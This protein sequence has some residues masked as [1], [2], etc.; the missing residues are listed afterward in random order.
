LNQQQRFGIC[1]CWDQHRVGSV[2]VINTYV[3]ASPPQVAL[4]ED[5]GSNDVWY[6]VLV[7][8]SFQLS[9]FKD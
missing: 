6:R 1:E 8:I 7:R 9:A 4:E 3:T 5:W 2:D